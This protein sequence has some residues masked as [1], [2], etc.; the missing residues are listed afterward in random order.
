VVVK[1]ENGFEVGDWYTD[2]ILNLMKLTNNL[3][4]LIAFTL[5]IISTIPIILVFVIRRQLVRHICILILMYLR[6][7]LIIFV[8][9]I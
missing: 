4:L 8:I 1:I 7:L 6:L 3:I 2:S 9:T 5:L